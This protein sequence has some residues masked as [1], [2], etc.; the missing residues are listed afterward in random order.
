MIHMSDEFVGDVAV[1]TGGAAGIG[2]EISLALA[3]AGV[4]VLAIDIDLAGLEETKMLS[5]VRGGELQVFQCDVADSKSVKLAFEYSEKEFGYCTI[6]VAA[7]AIAL[8][9]D[10]L[11]M[12][13]KDMDRTIAV[14]LK[15]PLLCAQESLRQMEKVGKG[16]IVFISS[17]QA[18]MSLFGCVVYAATKS[19]L[20]A[21]ARTL[22]L[23]TGKMGIRVNTI[24]PGTIDTPMLDRDLASMNREE[25]ATFLEKVRAA[26]VLGRIGTPAEIADAV[27]YLASSKASYVTGIDLRV[28]AGFSALKN[29]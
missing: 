28:D 25:A 11:S 15:G 20:I 18:V 26:N 3:S 29:F 17:V 10:Y 8:Y 13:E 1:V 24:S 27:K 6:M 22:A 2:R 21:A 4:K 5:T 23:E 16:S 12:S 7:A 14:N 9:T 19:G